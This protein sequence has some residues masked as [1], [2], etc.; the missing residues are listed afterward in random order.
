MYI[1][2]YIHIF[3]Y[4]YIYIYMYIQSFAKAR[5]LPNRGARGF[6]EAG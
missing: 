6:R 3:I 5:E 1:K 2:K 4:I